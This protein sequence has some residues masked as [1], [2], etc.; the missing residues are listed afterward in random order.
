MHPLLPIEVNHVEKLKKL[1]I[2]SINHARSVVEEAA[3]KK[4]AGK[5]YPELSDKAGLCQRALV[6]P[7]AFRTQMRWMLKEQEEANQQ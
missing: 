1:G 6:N 5:L 2:T 7:D 3:K 4:R